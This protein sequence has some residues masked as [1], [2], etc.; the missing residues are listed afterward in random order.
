MPLLVWSACSLLLCSFFAVSAPAKSYQI[1]R[2]EPANWWAGM[3]HSQLQLLVYGKDIAQLTPGLSYHGVSLTGVE[4]TANPNYLFVNL[5]LAA[6]V[7]PG[8]IALHFSLNGETLLSHSY[9]LLQRREA[10]A[11]RLGFNPADVIYL[12]TPDRFANGNPAND[13]MPGMHEQANRNNEHGRH[14]GD[15]AGMQNALPYIAD[16]GFTAIWPTPLTE[17]N[18]SAYSYHGYAATDLYNIDARFGTNSQYRDFVAAANSKGIKV[19]Q[20][21]ILNHIGSEHWWLKD[22]PD[23]N[24]LNN[25]SFLTSTAFIG[26]NHNR[27]TVQDP[28]ASLVDS[29][30]FTD[31]W[32]VD[33]MPDL[34]QRHPLLATYLIQNSIWWVEY[35]NLA[36]IR[37]D[38][39]SYADKAF[40]SE[41]ARRIMLEYPNFNIVGE[42][43]SPNPLIVSYWQ[44]GKQNRDDYVSHTPSMLDFPLYDALLK[45]LISEESWNGGW[46]SLYEMLSN[47]HVYADPFNLVTFEGNH[48]TARIFS[49]LNED[50]NLY[51]MAISYLLTMRGIPQLFYGTEIAMQSL[52][53]RDD[54]KVRADFPGG[55]A[56]DKVNAFSGNGL[57]ST[58]K[59]AQQLVKALLNWRKTASAIH[60]GKL[61]HFAPDNGTYTY[62]RYNDSQTVMVVMNKQLQPVALDLARFNEVLPQGKNATEVITGKNIKLDKQLTVPARGTLVLDIR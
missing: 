41:W 39:Y 42:E 57:N 27:S 30:Q 8:D 34:N 47:D 9:P 53:V 62:F 48:D 46:I 60:S 23:N 26:T 25:Q 36:G 4:R 54:G 59:S 19:I 14:G 16:M 45:A 10:S 18:Q 50:M 29:T 33:T 56:G 49:L 20:D 6:D 38:T 44:R 32:F 40:L 7:Q 51:R 11:K 12:L 55:W 58:Q 15:L 17:N 3:Q 5:S 37:E 31:G 13:N 22:L 43:W 28:Y 61:M 21:I 35:A 2:L 52:K 24:W 1:E